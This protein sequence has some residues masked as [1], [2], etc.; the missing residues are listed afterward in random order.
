MLFNK[1]PKDWTKTR[2]EGVNYTVY[3]RT[4]SVMIIDILWFILVNHAPSSHYF[5]CSCY[6]EVGQFII[7]LWHLCFQCSFVMFVI[8]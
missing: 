1:I 4:H 6:E 2:L 3:Y 7:D 5:V 8:V